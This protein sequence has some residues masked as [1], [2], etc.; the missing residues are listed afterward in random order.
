MVGIFE[1]LDIGGDETDV[2]ERVDGEESERAL[3][4]FE[5][6]V[7]EEEMIGGSGVVDEKRG[8]ED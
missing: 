5:F 6:D 7:E 1:N 3:R 8:R 4:V 2:G